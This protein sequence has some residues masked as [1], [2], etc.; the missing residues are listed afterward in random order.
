MQI[1]NDRSI[2]VSTGTGRKCTNWQPAVMTLGELYDRLHTPIRGEETLAAYMQMSKTERDNRKDIGGF[3]GGQLAG[4]RKKANVQGRD[5]VTLASTICRR[6]RQQ[7]S[8]GAVPVWVS[9]TACIPRASTARKHRVCASLC[10][11]TTPCSRTSTSRSAAGW[12]S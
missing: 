12:Q 2:T 8:C 5:L 3:V 7:R 10:R 11:P 1:I 4:R 9:V 6:A